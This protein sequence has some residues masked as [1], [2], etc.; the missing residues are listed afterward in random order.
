MSLRSYRIYLLGFRAVDSDK[1]PITEYHLLNETRFVID[2]QTGDL[3]TN[4]S[5]DYEDTQ[6]IDLKITATDPKLDNYNATDSNVVTVMVNF[7][8]LN[9]NE[10]TFEL[11]E[12]VKFNENVPIG[13]TLV[14]VK[15]LDNE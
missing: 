2:R 11:I 3:F 9:D 15:C 6:R 13:S 7:I 4:A 5:L 14:Q 12:E 8:D 1:D 10:P